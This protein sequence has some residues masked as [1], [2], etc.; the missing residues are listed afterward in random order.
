MESIFLW[1]ALTPLQAE[2][3]Q[4][5]RRISPDIDSAR[6]DL[7]ATT[8]PVG[9]AAD[10]Q[11]YDEFSYW[12]YTLIRVEITALGYF[13]KMEANV[14][15]RTCPG[16]FRWYGLMMPEETDDQGRLLY[17]VIEQPTELTTFTREQRDGRN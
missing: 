3:L 4:S 15:E 7:S 8:A 16:E 1:M 13:R 17:K 12:D 5:H 14:L 6:I 10:I 2:E 9:R 11:Q